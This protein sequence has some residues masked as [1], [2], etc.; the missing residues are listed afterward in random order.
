MQN[1]LTYVTFAAIM[2]AMPLLTHAELKPKGLAADNRIRTVTYDPNNVVM[3]NSHYG[4]QTD[5]VFGKDEEIQNVAIGDAL[6]WQAVPT[7]QHLFLK[8]MAASK[9]N[10]TVLTN[11]RSYNFQIVS[12]NTPKTS[13]TYKLEFFYP[14]EAALISSSTV[15]EAANLNPM[16]VNWRYSYKG[17]KELLPT[18]IF[19]NGQFTY[20]KF[21]ENGMSR[22]PA[23]FIVN[24]DRTETLVNYHMERHKDSSY[25]VINRTAKQ[26]T[27]RD[28]TLST[29]IFNDYAIGDWKTMAG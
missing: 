21:P 27:L 25:L 3:L 28:G 23:I 29:C 9:T 16:E 1:R 8:P 14:D 13:P 22:L 18:Q 7:H 10:M 26:F 12:T 24:K 5:I 20:F 2:L 4:Y 19:D 6:S 15:A 11:K 17:D